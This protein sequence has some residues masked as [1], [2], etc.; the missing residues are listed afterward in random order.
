[1]LE[2]ATQASVGVSDH[3]L[4]FERHFTLPSEV[5]AD[6]LEAEYRNGVLYIVLPKHEKA[7]ARRIE[8]K[9]RDEAR[10]TSGRSVD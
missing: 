7:K 8:V 6:E 9:R 5:S 1:V 4:E 3:S 10:L 2:R